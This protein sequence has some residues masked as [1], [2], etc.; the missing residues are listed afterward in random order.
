MSS[1]DVSPESPE[2]PSVALWG[3][4]ELPSASQ[5]T[6]PRAESSRICPRGAVAVAEVE[7]INGTYPVARD[8]IDG[9]SNGVTFNSLANNSASAPIADSIRA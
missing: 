6:V 8:G 2:S 5:K 4:R 9:L 7:I 3:V 1:P